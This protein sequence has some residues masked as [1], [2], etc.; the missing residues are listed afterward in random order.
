MTPRFETLINQYAMRDHTLVVLFLITLSL[1][2]AWIIADRGFIK[3]RFRAFLRALVPDSILVL[4]L[5]TLI[6]SVRG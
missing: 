2:V 6:Y 3:S 5:L 4:L 1:V